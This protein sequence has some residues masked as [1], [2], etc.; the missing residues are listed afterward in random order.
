MYILKLISNTTQSILN[1]FFKFLN[2]L[3]IDCLWGKGIELCGLGKIKFLNS[4]LY[5][6]K[7]KNGMKIRKYIKYKLVKI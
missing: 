2:I 5:S 7:F 3:N 6:K 1:N 4:K